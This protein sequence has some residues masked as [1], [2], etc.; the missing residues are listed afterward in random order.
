MTY[1]I[2]LTPEHE[3]K[4]RRYMKREEW[5]SFS[6]SSETEKYD[7]SRIG[8]AFEKEKTMKATILPMLLKEIGEERR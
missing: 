2:S 7:P 8:I 3:K 4:I 1:E 5:E 6:V